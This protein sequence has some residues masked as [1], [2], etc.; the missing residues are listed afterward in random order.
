[1]TRWAGC[2]LVL[3]L[4]AGV[5][6]GQKADVIQEI[7]G[8]VPDPRPNALGGG[9][10]LVPQPQL[11][12]K[13]LAAL[14][15]LPPG[16][17]RPDGPKPGPNVRPIRSVYTLPG[18]PKLDPHGDP[19]PAGAVTRYGTVRL[20]HGTD[21]N[22]IGFTPDGKRL[23][24]VSATDDT[25]RLWD[26]ATGK[27]VGRLNA[28]PLL[29]TLARDG[30]VYVVEDA[31][32]KVWLPDA[33]TTRTLPD[34]T[35]PEGATPTAIAVNPD[36]RSF[37]L[38][39]GDKI[40]IL[41]AQSGKVAR[42][43]NLPGAPQ[44]NGNGRA[45]LPGNQPN[46]QPGPPP[47]RMLFSPDGRWLVGSGQR[48]GVWLWDLR[49]G[50]RVRTYRS[51]LDFPEYTFSPDITKLVVTGQ[52]LHLYALDAEEPVVGFKSDD[53]GGLFAPRYSA[54]GKT[55]F[56]VANDGEVV[57]FDAT[58][59]ARGDPL[60]PPDQNLR[61][62]FALAPGGAALA[63]VDQTGGIRIW[64]PET[65]KGPEVTRLPIL[66]D[67]GFS[68][69]GKLV[70][71]ID[72][73]NKVHTFD[74]VTGAPGKAIELPGDD[75]GLPATWD[76]TSR[77]AAVIVP[78]GD[79]LELQVIDADT[80]KAISKHAVPPNA[81]IPFVQFATANR[82]RLAMFS[83][84]AVTV[85]N[86]TTGKLVRSFTIPN[87]ENGDFRGG[88]TPDG[89]LVAMPTRPPT[90]WEVS[91]GK[92]RL[93]LDALK[94]VE[95]FSADSR[96]AAGPDDSNNVAVVDVRTGAVVRRL[97]L[98]AEAGGPDTLAFSA[99]GKRLAIGMDDGRVTVWDV[100]AG[101][102]L[103]PFAGHDAFV[104]GLA[105]SADGKRL[106]S[107]ANDGTALVWA[108]PDKAVSAGPAETAVN[109]FV[110]AFTLLGSTDAAQAQRGLDYIYRHPAEGAKQAGQRVPVPAPTPAATVARHIDDLASEDFKTREGAK[111]ALAALTGEAGPALKVAAEKSAS[112]EVRKTASELLN[113]ID[114]P[115][116]KPDDLRILRAV[117]AMEN[118]RTADG[119]AQLD[120]WAAGPPG[121]RLT[122]EATA[123]LA[124][125][126]ATGEK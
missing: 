62:P 92:K 96:F 40:L 34:K 97:S 85:V 63:A 24:T 103:A 99:D 37:A 21:V 4:I 106:A 1:M 118:L 64:N 51:E 104:T 88:I 77:R 38:A 65:G 84:N 113:K 25:V 54:D 67:P 12:A 58:T 123:A 86:P 89:R 116:T 14:N 20:R 15:P 83:P 124:R 6:Y 101:E 5:G 2:G 57:P 49:T 71:V 76:A 112:A 82:D 111:A 105:F 81:G 110:E 61:P 91:T 32:V 48:T 29:V 11:L 68:P 87:D 78:S 60:A 39:A 66:S 47:V 94:G 27:E 9:V 126:K 72:A 3:V 69:D 122:V 19:L 42:E 52:R 73:E 100:T 56:A 30:S 70:T 90:L 36:G 7:V 33:N 74:A 120:K 8:F 121:H 102:V 35:V 115:A 46:P 53:S 50:K 93:T 26:P 108:V 109:G 98:P 79:D 28:S 75:N 125:L 16:N 95:A 119:R 55:I 59:G 22:G 17:E 43:L 13:K 44:N 117:E 45:G 41:D 10:I 23:C 31:A 114:A 80:G 18:P 107:T